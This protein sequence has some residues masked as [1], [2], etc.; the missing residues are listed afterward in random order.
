[1]A[2]EDGNS[3]K[4]TFYFTD[5]TDQT[6]T[7]TRP[8]EPNTWHSGVTDPNLNPNLGKNGD[9]Y[10]DK[11]TLTI[12]QKSGGRWIAIATL[13]NTKDEHIVTFDPNGGNFVSGTLD[14]QFPI[15]HGYTFY[16][17]DGYSIPSVYRDGYTFVGWFTSKQNDPNAGQFTDL[18][19][20]LSDMTLYARWEQN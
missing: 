14:Y 13:S 8:T 3:Y 7:F 11:Y 1:M 17:T 10:I 2:S 5:G 19:P 20:V 15:T 6:V 4:L 16:S 9:F 18:T 12:Y